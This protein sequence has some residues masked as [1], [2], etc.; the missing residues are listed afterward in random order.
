MQ[1]TFYLFVRVR[2]LYNY[3]TILYRKPSM[4]MNV[5]SVFVFSNNLKHLIRTQKRSR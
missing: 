4:F 5:P 3:Y 2:C 1:R